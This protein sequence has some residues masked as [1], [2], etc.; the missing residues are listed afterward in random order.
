MISCT[1]NKRDDAQIRNDIID[2]TKH[3]NKV[4]ETLNVDS[5]AQFHSD[6]NFAYYWHGGLASD[7]NDQFRK[8]F[9]SILSGTKEWSMKTEQPLVQVINE[10]A[11]VISFTFQAQSTE[12][13]GKKSNESGAL[14]YLWNKVNDKW[15]LIH[16]HESAK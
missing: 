3:Y 13:D 7:N 1:Q 11:A 16:I 10:N 5:I 2:I 6:A 8:L 15:K 4:W 12:M 9:S 14:T